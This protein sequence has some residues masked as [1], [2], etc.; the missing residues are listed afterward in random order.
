MGLLQGNGVSQRLGAKLAERQAMHCTNSIMIN[1]GLYIQLYQRSFFAYFV[2][3]DAGLRKLDRAFTIVK[4]SNYRTRVMSI[5]LLKRDE[6]GR[7]AL[8]NPLQMQ[9]DIRV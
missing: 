6:R 1:T 9:G 8:Y 2:E 4:E 7:S 5:Q 3:G